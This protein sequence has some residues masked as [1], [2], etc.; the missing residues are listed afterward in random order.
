MPIY[1]ERQQWLSALFKPIRV[2]LAD[3]AYSITA[4]AMDHQQVPQEVLLNGMQLLK[5]ST[6]HLQAH[7]QTKRPLLSSQPPFQIGAFPPQTAYNIHHLYSACKGTVP[8][9]AL[10]CKH[11]FLP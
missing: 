5:T 2:L 1:A 6:H 7:H 8:E 9:A 3:N 10:C 4:E 11:I